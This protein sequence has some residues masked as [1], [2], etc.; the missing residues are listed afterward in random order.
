LIG[1]EIWREKK[2]AHVFL[3]LLTSAVWDCIDE[4]CF[5]SGINDS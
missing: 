5:R 3:P 1:H 4:S 2:L